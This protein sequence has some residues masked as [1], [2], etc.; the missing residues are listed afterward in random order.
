M[1]KL[2]TT[3]I[4]FTCHAAPASPPDNVNAIPLSSTTI[5]VTWNIVPPIHQNGPIIVYEVMYAPMQ[6]FDGQIM[7]RTTNT[8]TVS[9]TFT[10]LQEYV[11][12][13][14][15]VRAYTIIGPGPYSSP[16]VQSL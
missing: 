6:T 13:S 12:Y 4:S 2:Y 8:S 7:T 14:I 16:V 9:L 1:K 5:M 10:K 15:S 3:P 11:V